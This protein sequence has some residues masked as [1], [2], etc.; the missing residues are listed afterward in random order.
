MRDE[1]ESHLQ[2]WSHFLDFRLYLR[3]QSITDENVLDVVA[4]QKL[5]NIL[6]ALHFLGQSVILSLGPSPG[7]WSRPT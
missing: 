5:R 6:T 4:E 7:K 2:F 1:T 3:L